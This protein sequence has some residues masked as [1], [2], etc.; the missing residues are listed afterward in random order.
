MTMLSCDDD[1]ENNEVEV[2]DDDE[3]STGT[4]SIDVTTVKAMTNEGMDNDVE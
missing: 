3:M 1:E 2:E 4:M